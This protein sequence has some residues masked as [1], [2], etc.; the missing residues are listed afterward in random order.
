MIPGDVIY[1]RNKA[2]KLKVQM[3]KQLNLRDVML[4]VGVDKLP[5][6]DSPRLEIH[7]DGND[8]II[9]LCDEA[10]GANLPAEIY[11][12]FLGYKDAT[13]WKGHFDEPEENESIYETIS[14]E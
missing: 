1:L 4:C 12:V 2:G 11:V 7:S 8:T 6:M 14:Y 3:D 10:T 13:A 5:S 9:T